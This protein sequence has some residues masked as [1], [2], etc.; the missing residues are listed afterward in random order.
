MQHKKCFV[1]EETVANTHY[2]SM[3]IKKIIN[4]N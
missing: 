1:K 4:W 2:S 3:G